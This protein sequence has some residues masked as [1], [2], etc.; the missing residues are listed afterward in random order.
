MRF[1]KFFLVPT[2]LQKLVRKSLQKTFFVQKNFGIFCIFEHNIKAHAD[3]HKTM[4]VVFRKQTQTHI[5]IYVLKPHA[6]LQF[7]DLSDRVE[8]FTKL[9]E[10]VTQSVLQYQ[11]P[12]SPSHPPHMLWKRYLHPDQ[13]NTFYIILP[14]AIHALLDDS[15]PAQHEIYKIYIPYIALGPMRSVCLSYLYHTDIL[16]LYLCS[17]A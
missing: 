7:N 12:S 4:I 14:G 3:S 11:Q 5:H 10:R 16:Q 6:T 1:I 17:L 9:E 8:L 15:L 2:T 13:H